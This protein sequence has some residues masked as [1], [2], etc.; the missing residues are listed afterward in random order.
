MGKATNTE[1]TEKQYNRGGIFTGVSHMLS[2][3]GGVVGMI[4]LSLSAAVIQ[5][6]RVAARLPFLLAMASIML[7]GLFPAVSQ[8]LAAIPT[9]VAYAAMFITYTSLLGFGLQDFASQP[10]DQRTITIAGGSLLTGIGIMFVP[11]V[12]WQNMPPLF[13]F[14]FGNGLLLG[15]IVCLILEHLVFPKRKGKETEKDGRAA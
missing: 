15:V 14:L 12:A 13:S 7:I 9:P 5:T 2:G 6:S 8:F 3:A 1:P 11:A 10:M 4:P